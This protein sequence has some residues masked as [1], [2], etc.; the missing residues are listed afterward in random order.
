VIPFEQEV[1]GKNPWISLMFLTP[2]PWAPQM[3]AVSFVTVLAPSKRSHEE[4][5]MRHPHAPMASV[6]CSCTSLAEYLVA[7]G[8]SRELRRMRCWTSCRTSAAACHRCVWMPVCPTLPS[9]TRS[10][11]M[12]FQAVAKQKAANAGFASHRSHHAVDE[13]H[14]VLV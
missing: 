14:D 11:K 2:I 10:R 12:R 6:S 8:W 1:L 13:R 3:W 5:D 9:G 7:Y 4:H